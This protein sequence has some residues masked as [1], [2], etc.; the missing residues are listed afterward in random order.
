[1]SDIA[2]PEAV[3]GGLFKG[4]DGKASGRKITGFLGFFFGAGLGAWAIYLKLPWT[5]I[6]VVMGVPFCFSLLMYGILTMQNVKEIVGSLKG[7]QG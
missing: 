6:L 4:S 1:M 7:V 2:E 3:K 5:G